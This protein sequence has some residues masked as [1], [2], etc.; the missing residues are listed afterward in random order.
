[1]IR[2]VQIFNIIIIYFIKMYF[3]IRDSLLMIY[4]F[5]NL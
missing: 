5:Y 4:L 1:M 2:L 3:I